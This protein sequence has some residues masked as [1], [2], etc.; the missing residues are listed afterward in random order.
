[1]TGIS[2]APLAA[3]RQMIAMAFLRECQALH[4]ALQLSGVP[5]QQAATLIAEALLDAAVMM[6]RTAHIN[7]GRAPDLTGLASAFT[8]SCETAHRLVHADT[9]QPVTLN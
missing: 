5:D 3:H 2:E 6:Q 9:L 8:R 7:D 4:V 1:M